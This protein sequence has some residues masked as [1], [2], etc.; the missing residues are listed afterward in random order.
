MAKIY[1][2]V[3]LRF[4]REKTPVFTTEETPFIPGKAEIFWEGK[5]PQVVIIGAGPILYNALL[6]AKELE[7]ENIGVLVLNSHTIKPIDEKKLLK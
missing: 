7:D 5:K 3:Y 6:A 1:G 4:A 2:P